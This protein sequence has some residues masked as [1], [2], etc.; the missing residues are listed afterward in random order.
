MNRS[1]RQSRRRRGFTLVELL[2]AV[3]LVVLM[4]T[5]FAEIFALATDAVSTQRGIAANDQKIRTFTTLLRTDIEA[6]TFRDVMPFQTVDMTPPGEEVNAFNNV[7]SDPNLNERRRGYFAISENDPDDPTDD[8]LAFTI[9]LGSK[10]VRVTDALP[11]MYGRAENRSVKGDFANHPE[12]DDG[13]ANNGQGASTM[14]EIAYFLRN[15]NLYRSVRLIREPYVGSGQPSDDAGNDLFTDAEPRFWGRFDY[16][17]FRNPTTAD[18]PEAV[19]FHT[20]GSL[21]NGLVGSSTG[22]IL[23]GGEDVPPALGIPHLRFGHTING[24]GGSGRPDE[25]VPMLPSGDPVF[26]GRWLQQ[27]MASNQFNY[28]GT[29]GA[30]P[31]ET[32]TGFDPN[33]GLVAPYNDTSARRGAELLV[34][35]VHEFDIQVWDDDPKLPAPMWTDIGANHTIDG[36]DDGTPDGFYHRNKNANTAYCPPNRYRFDTWHPQLGSP[37]PFRGVHHFTAGGTPPSTSPDGQPGDAGVA[38]TG[39]YGSITEDRRVGWIGSDDE[40]PLR[41]IRVRVRFY[42]V[43]SGQIRQ[44]TLTLPLTDNETL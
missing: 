36:D 10:N 26:I 28:P 32:A 33:T 4:M 35:N 43:N 39:G 7:F 22:T 6:R 31:A 20:G 42:D 30:G 15:G 29:N 12:F 34:P 38:T 11:L 21:D 40:R 23:V 27:E 5:M 9:D 24:N 2:V 18:P 8:V 1:L 3:A 16:S 25:F 41:Q 13:L 14:A 19:R 44:L 17:A 37:A